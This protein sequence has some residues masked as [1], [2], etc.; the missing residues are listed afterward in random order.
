MPEVRINLVSLGYMPHFV[1]FERIKS[2]KSKVFRVVSFDRVELLPN[3]D[4]SLWSY[5]DARLEEK[6]P[7]P[8]EA[9]FT[10]AL[11]NLPL[12]QNYY[13]R[14]IAGNRIAI[15]AY[16]IADVLIA[17]D[18]P[19][20]NYMLR[21]LYKY[22][23]V[24]KRYG[25][26][27]VVGEGI[28]SHDETR[29]CLFDMT[30]MKTDIIY[31]TE[32]LGLCEECRIELKKSG[33]STSFLDNLEDELKKVRKGTYYRILGFIKRRPILAIAISALGA[34]LINILSFALYEYLVSL[35]Q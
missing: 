15:S 5:T 9:D 30:P 16:E 13:A 28:L 7:A 24:F 2:W 18:V 29:V 11:I 8:A 12:E 10:L 23:T 31:S 19:L 21:M 34:I 26:I 33:V 4:G 3:S 22:A 35:F 20:E 1:D 27:P 32:R 14:R 6:V 17:S 25:C